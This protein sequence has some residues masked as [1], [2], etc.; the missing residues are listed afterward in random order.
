M[1]ATICDFCKCQIKNR[2]EDGIQV[3]S[4]FKVSITPIDSR[5]NPANGKEEYIEYRNLDICYACADKLV[6]TVLKNR[7]L[8][9]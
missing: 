4:N 1:R 7:G 9:G 3:T 2:D 5:V 8:K 6:E